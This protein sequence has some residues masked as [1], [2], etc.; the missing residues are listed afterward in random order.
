[1]RWVLA[2]AVLL[3]SLTACTGGDLKEAP[4][5]P[6]ADEAEA[7]DVIEASSAF[8]EADYFPESDEFVGM[9][10]DIITP[11]DWIGYIRLWAD[12][13]EDA[14]LAPAVTTVRTCL[15]DVNWLAM[16]G[17]GLEGDDLEIYG[18]RIELT[19]GPHGATSCGTVTLEGAIFHRPLD[20]RVIRIDEVSG[21][22]TCLDGYW[23][24]PVM[25]R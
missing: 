15:L 1:M 19:T 13:F 18:G 8:S 4:S 12:E 5:C 10:A 24:E 16:W 22:L 9:F 14:I 23:G 6:P 20:G 11:D 3:G 7:V 2:R 21:P 25:D 17:H